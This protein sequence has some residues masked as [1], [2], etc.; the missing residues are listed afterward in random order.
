MRTSRCFLH[1]HAFITSSLLRT[2]GWWPCFLLSQESFRNQERT[3]PFS[4]EH[5]TKLLSLY[6]VLLPFLRHSPSA[7]QTPTQAADATSLASFPGSASPTCSS[8]FCFVMILSTG[9]S[10]ILKYKFSLDPLIFSINLFW[11]PWECAGR[12][13]MKGGVLDWGPQPLTSG[14]YPALAVS[15]RLLHTAP[16]QS[17]AGTLTQIPCCRHKI[18]LLVSPSSRTEVFVELLVD[19]GHAGG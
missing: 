9:S 7:C 2:L 15:Q 14:I 18:P 6:W 1:P 17:L 3:R 13:P 12:S 8:L 10:A 5:F 4:T 19:N 16:G 11:W